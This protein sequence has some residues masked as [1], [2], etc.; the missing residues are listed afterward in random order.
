M[1]LP[2]LHCSALLVNSWGSPVIG[3]EVGQ[4]SVPKSVQPGPKGLVTTMRTIPREKYFKHIMLS[5]R[6]ESLLGRSGGFT[7]ADPG[8]L[9]CVSLCVIQIAT[10]N[11]GVPEVNNEN[12]PL[13]QWCHS[14]KTRWY[15]SQWQ[16]YTA[17]TAF[18]K[19]CHRSHIPHGLYG[20]KTMPY[21]YLCDSTESHLQWWRPSRRQHPHRLLACDIQI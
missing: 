8:F 7:W 10:L 20:C 12:K 9:V 21:T 14:S 16:V 15:S 18:K 11:K 1:I 17:L 5:Y 4:G 3:W 19:P 2:T 13:A 6:F